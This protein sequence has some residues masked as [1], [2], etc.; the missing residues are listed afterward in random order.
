MKALAFLALFFATTAGFA[1]DAPTAAM[2]NTNDVFAWVTNTLRPWLTRSYPEINSKFYPEW[3]HDHPGGLVPGPF[4]NWLG[5]AFPDLETE[6]FPTWLDNFVPDTVGTNIPAWWGIM[7]KGKYSV[8][9]AAQPLPTIVR[10][11]YLQLGTTNSMVVRWRTDLP[12]PSAV[13]F[14][15]SVN[16]LNR[17]GRA[18]GIFTEHAV[19]LTNLAP[20]TKYY[21]ALGPIDTPLLVRLTN[22]IV[23][24]SSTNSRIYVNKPRT[25]EQIAVANRDTFVLIRNKKRFTVTDL[26]NSF[27]ANTTNQ[28]LIVNTPNN[29]VLL[30]IT[31]NTIVV[32]TSNH[33]S[34]LDGGPSPRTA[35][36]AGRNFL[37]G[38]T[39]L[40]RTGGDSNTFF[41]SH[42]PIGPSKPTRVWVL[43]D[44]GTRKKAERDVRDA[45]YQWTGERSTD[46]WLMLGDNAYTAGKDTEYQGAV[47]DMYGAMLRRAVLWPCLG[48]HD[49]GSA[50][51]PIQF[52]V[53]YDIFTLPAQAQ[54]GGVM[55]GSEAYYSFDY[56][57]LHVVC[58]DSSDSDWAKTSLMLRWL[59]AD[60][61]TNKQ[62]WLIAYCHHPPY[63]RGS[64][65]SDNDR[66][67]EGRMRAIRETVVP[68]L[69]EHGLD[70]MLCGHSHAYERSHLL[71]GFYGRSTNLNEQVHFKSKND[72]RPT[73]NGTGIY[74]KPTRGPAPHEGA[75][76]VVAGSSGQ[77][78][79][80]R[81]QHPVHVISLNVLGSLVLDFDG[82]RLDATF[83]DDKAAV[84][85]QFAIVKGPPADVNEPPQ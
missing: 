69:E 29:A 21:Y 64:H 70:L 19:Q 72:G 65:N 2:V 9:P 51:S 53:Y 71:D 76:Y 60:L 13:S 24:L 48:N 35:R 22:D 83:I 59:K 61:Q 31:N 85:D 8:S 75:V 5:N 50:N 15:T 6:M 52:G 39:N 77:T 67:S 28:S 44:P 12:S 84:R 3:L 38:T 37:V 73:P 25:R 32:T 62:D 46:F 80:G 56:A 74:L 66:D 79:G 17:T 40:I 41:V 82:P 26:E 57:N 33:V 14:G 36:L 58:L 34:W 4:T 18:N 43:G 20:A 45:Y 47:F 10:G 1:A 63:T 42:P 16:R 23:F 68:M 27:T 7:L 55:S 49:A 81:L 78:S 54:A 11:P 30:T